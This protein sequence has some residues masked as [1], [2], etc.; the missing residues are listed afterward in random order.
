MNSALPAPRSSRSCP[1]RPPQPGPALPA[2]RPRPAPSR[3]R[4]SPPYIVLTGNPN[5]G[6]TTLFNALTGLRAKV[7]NY[8]G[9]DGGAQGGPFARRARRPER[10]RAGFARHLQPQPAVAGRTNLARRAAQP[11]ARAA[12]ALG[13]RRGGGCVEFAAQPLLRQPG[14]RAGVSDA[15]CAEHDGCG[16]G[17]RA[18]D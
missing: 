2:R 12:R 1:L 8:A 6:K 16:G 7:G 4:L 3:A 11:A 18:P 15:D 5:S 9:R 10:A 13:D 14:D 17:E